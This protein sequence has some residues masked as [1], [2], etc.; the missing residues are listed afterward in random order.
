MNQKKL[1]AASVAA[2]CLAMTTSA[3]AADYSN[4]TGTADGT[5]LAGHLNST[6]D[7][8]IS[9]NDTFENNKLTFNATNGQTTAAGIAAFHTSVT[10]KDGTFTSNEVSDSDG[11]INGVYGTAVGV[12]GA[13]GSSAL[14]ITN[15]TFTSNKGTSYNQ[16]EGGAVYQSIGT[17]TLRVQRSTRM[18]QRLQKNL[19][20]ITPLLWAERFRCGEQ[21][22]SLKTQLSQTTRRPL[23]QKKAPALA[24]PS[25]SVAEFGAEQRISQPPSRI[26]PLTAI[27]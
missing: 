27:R 11:S 3:L 21:R 10:V 16:T 26:R 22:Q 6:T 9:T 19:R 1:L 13:D 17:A 8:I 5:T 7:A 18:L 25:T 4:H 12:T 20:K 24:A 14:T 15:S 23:M 2:A